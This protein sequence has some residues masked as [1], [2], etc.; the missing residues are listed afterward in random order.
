MLYRYFVMKKIFLS[1]FLPILN[2]LVFGIL[3]TL[4][5][6]AQYTISPTMLVT[7]I[8]CICGGVIPIYI[9]IRYKINISEYFFYYLKI[10]GGYFFISFISMIFILI[11]L[12]L[13]LL[14]LLILLICTIIIYWHMSDDRIK[15]VIFTII[16]PVLY[17]SILILIFIIEF[18]IYGLK[19]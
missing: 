16:N 5:L 1:L 3:S 2:L 14:I 18:A 7:F 9:I 13:Y 12:T 11:S 15:K 10:L 19:F 8:S 6:L 4:F 17:I